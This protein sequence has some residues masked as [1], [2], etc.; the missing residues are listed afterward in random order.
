MTTATDLC[1]L[2]LVLIG[3][4]QLTNV[5]TDTTKAALLCNAMYQDAI[6]DVLA[7]NDWSCAKARANL[8]YRKDTIS[9]ISLANPAVITFDATSAASYKNGDKIYIES[10]TT[11][12]ATL[13]SYL[14]ETVFT[15]K[16]K[17]GDTFQ[18]YSED[19]EDAIDTSAYSNAVTAGESRVYDHEYGYRFDLPSDFITSRGLYGTEAEWEIEENYIYCDEDEITLVYTKEITTITTLSK[20]LHTPIA[21]NLA[22]RLVDSIKGEGSDG[23]YKLYMTQLHLAKRAEGRWKQERDHY[24]DYQLAVDV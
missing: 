9:G 2:A 20:W 18:L 10:V 22:F 6:N 14:E 21:F 24:G 7:E 15:L 12:D 23:Y 17:T 13:E 11:D 16:G 4:K 3:E 19:G 8:S 1:N 5:A